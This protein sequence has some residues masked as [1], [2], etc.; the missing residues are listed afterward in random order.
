MKSVKHRYSFH[1]T[2]SN[3]ARI[4]AVGTFPQRLIQRFSSPPSVWGVTRGEEAI[5][6]PQTIEEAPPEQKFIEVR[7]FDPENFSGA[8]NQILRY[9]K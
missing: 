1:V 3:M 7:I 9:P 8:H 5:A 2:L 4:E 6:E